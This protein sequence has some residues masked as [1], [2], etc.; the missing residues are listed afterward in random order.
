MD[1]TTDDVNARCRTTPEN[2]PFTGCDCR[3]TKPKEAANETSTSARMWREETRA[4]PPI[5]ETIMNGEENPGLVSGRVYDFYGGAIICQWW[6]DWIGT[7][8]RE[9]KRGR[10]RPLNLR[11][12]PGLCRES[13]GVSHRASIGTYS[14][15]IS[16]VYSSRGRIRMLSLYC[17]THWRVQPGMRPRAKMDMNRSSGMS[18]R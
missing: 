1:C 11:F 9:K 8:V 18:S 6:I 7:G 13:T 5:S 17:S 15:S 12:M 14:K 10:N 4:T 16:P 3:P 2:L